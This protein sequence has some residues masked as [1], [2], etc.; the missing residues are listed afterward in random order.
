MINLLHINY[1]AFC[2]R[3]CFI[4]LT[5]FIAQ[6]ALCQNV[7]LSKKIT[8]NK[9]NSSIQELIEEISNQAGIN[10]SYSV[11]I[12]SI[13]N[14][15]SFSIKNKSLEETLKKL[16]K[17]FDVDYKIVEKQIVLKKTTNK[18]NKPKIERYTISGFLKDRESGESLIGATIL[19]KGTQKGTITNGYGYFSLT[20]P[21]GNYDIEFSY[22]GYIRERKHIE[23][24]NNIKIN[25]DLQYNS[26]IFEEVNVETKEYI[27]EIEKAQVSQINI[28]PKNIANIPEFIGGAGLIKSLQTL[29]G[30][31]VFSDGSA[32]FYV[33]GG[34]KDQN[35]ILIDE[36]PIYNP[37]HLFG[38]YSVIIPDVTKDIKIYKGDIPVSM[39]DRLS[40]VIDIKTKDGNLNK[41][42]TNGVLNPFVNRFSLEGPIVKEKSSF[43]ISYRHSN[44]KWIYKKAA[45][46]L[47]LYFYDL[48]AKFNIKLNRNNRLF[49]TF[50]FG[51]DNLS[52]INAELAHFGINWRNFTST[53]RWNHIYS[54]KLFSNTTLYSSSYN[55]DLSLAESENYKW[56][57]KIANL[58]LKT[59]FTYYSSPKHSLRFGASLNAHQF[60]PGNLNMNN[61]NI[62][63][64]PEI[65]SE[66]SVLYFSSNRKISNKISYSL[67]LRFE[68]C[69]NIGPTTVYGFDNN[70]NVNDT[71]LID[72]NKIFSVYSN[73]DPRINLKYQIDST[74]SV[75]LSYGTYH[76]YI[77]LLSNSIS[78][79][80]SL[81]VWLPSGTNIKPQSA[82]QY[83]LGYIK[84]FKNLN[85]E[86]TSDFYY[87]KMNNQIEYK[88]HA[89]M[90]LNPLIEG[91]LRFGEAWSYGAELMIKKTKGRCVGWINYTYSRVY[92]RTKDV[93]ENK[94][95]PAFYDRPH[96]FAVY[97]SYQ[98]SKRLGISANWVY[99]TG[100]AI[101]TPVGY[102]TY[103][104]SDI[105]VYGDEN[106]DR[107]PDYHRLDV[108]MN[109][110]LNK[111]VSRFQHRLIFSIYN[112][113]NRKNP[114][115]LNFNKVKTKNGEYV[116]PANIYGTDRIVTTQKYL[117]GFMPSITYK[118]RF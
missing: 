33:R 4:I 74:S 103:N 104:G 95:Y 21:K 99:N 44:L 43:F 107:M 75:K 100:S 80:T 47:N 67:G 73:L 63:K 53:L 113:Y 57:S 17:K 64:I 111:K 40:S 45:P 9:T 90:L 102:Y 49:Y 7:D 27:D 1:C 114:I 87:K 98:I 50:Y 58:S 68:S 106:N 71:I 20:L 92:K 112:A 15:I 5:L 24:N 42:E 108:A 2:K 72:T 30:I 93:N 86:F 29:P 101:T 94:K 36:A 18:D 81:E 69:G 22:I 16:S 38:F 85:F 91:E 26:E 84:F 10:F 62:P 76:Q 31:K 78:P 59:D 35:L 25:S 83:T 19:L 6:H 70:Y 23:L 110:R 56:I 66:K 61:I 118:F 54:E 65:K 117:L 60:N 97:L 8:V 14:N 88:S 11:Q 12:F 39:G 48:N 79:F 37:A 32:F 96:D 13:Q 105:P 82:H 51:E 77:Q 109:Y 55:Y 34:N 52:N 115:S 3:L 28:K 116:V 89:N 46:N 41:F